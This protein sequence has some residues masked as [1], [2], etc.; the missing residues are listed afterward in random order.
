M[1]PK[2]Q[3]NKDFLRLVF[4]D[5]KKLLKKADISYINV[6]HFEEISVKNLWA[7]LKDDEAF[8][9]YFNSKYAENRFPDRAYFFNM[10][11]TTYPNYLENIITNANK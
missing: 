4:Q 11:N 6:R 2:N 5:K 3:V 10:L 1:P 8:S 7:T 9:I